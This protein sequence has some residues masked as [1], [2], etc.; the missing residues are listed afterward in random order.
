M[1]ST[2]RRPCL[3]NG[4]WGPPYTWDAVDGFLAENGMV[5]VPY[6]LNKKV[7]LKF[8]SSLRK[9]EY[10]LCVIAGPLFWNFEILLN[11]AL[12]FA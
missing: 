3:A 5:N 2:G 11:F 4:N 1:S 6:S 12:G 10:F 7:Q 8:E 9:G